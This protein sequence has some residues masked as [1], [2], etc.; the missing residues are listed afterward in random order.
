MK[1]MHGNLGLSFVV[2]SRFSEFDKN[3]YRYKNSSNL[4]WMGITLNPNPQAAN[5]FFI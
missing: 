4:E 1:L 3:G 5:L 2:A